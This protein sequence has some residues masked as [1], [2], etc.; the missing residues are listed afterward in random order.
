M[1]RNRQRSS[2]NS[3]EYKITL[4]YIE[5]HGREFSDLD[6]QKPWRNLFSME[7]E[8]EKEE[9]IEIGLSFSVSLSYERFALLYERVIL[10]WVGLLIKSTCSLRRI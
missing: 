6:T 2:L 9:E 7:E 10:M 1:I 8:E 5:I 4:C 3:I